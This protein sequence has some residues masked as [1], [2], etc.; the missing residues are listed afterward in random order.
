MSSTLQNLL[1]ILGVVL[2]AGLG[3]YLYSQSNSFGL[4][5]SSGASAQVSADTTVLL[6]KLQ[7][8]Q[9]IKLEDQVFTDKRFEMLTN[10]TQP[11]TPSYIGKTNPFVAG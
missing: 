11:V 3:Y 6:H 8:L 5:T 1:I 9:T 10:F 2:L 7:S 4:N